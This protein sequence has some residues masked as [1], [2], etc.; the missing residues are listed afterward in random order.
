[1]SMD[2]WGGAILSIPIG[3]ATG[4]AVNP[5]QKW[6]ENRGKAKAA[7][8]LKDVK[9]QYER[10]LFY[11]LHPHLFTQYLLQTVIRTT[12]IGAAVGIL[13]GIFQA[14][15]HAFLFTFPTVVRGP[16]NPPQL[17]VI[18]GMGI[19]A[20]LTTVVGSVLIIRYCRP[21]IQLWHQVKTFE[22]Y[23]NSVPFEH[24]NLAAERLAKEI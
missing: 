1:M 2:M 7:I 15:T 12:F 3:I 20:Q 22:E 23:V 9:D 16:S 5:V 24:R 17:V 11:R 14:M 18:V 19:L 4:L 13:L 8:K 21:A 6:L 10:V